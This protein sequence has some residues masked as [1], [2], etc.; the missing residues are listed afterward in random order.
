MVVADSRALQPSISAI[1][2]T[3]TPATL[4]HHRS[5]YAADAGIHGEG[6]GGIDSEDG[7]VLVWHTS[8][9]QGLVLRSSAGEGL[10]AERTQGE[11]VMAVAMDGGEMVYLGPGDI[12]AGGDGRGLGQLV[13][14]K[15]EGGGL[16]LL[17]FIWR[18]GFKGLEQQDCGLWVG[19]MDSDEGSNSSC[20]T[21]V[22]AFAVGA[23]DKSPSFLMEA[24]RFACGYDDG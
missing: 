16:Q 10:L 15:Q 4:D 18:G 2:M 22:L 17:R 23:E 21:V 12:L 8:G 13:V 9:Q 5:N 1:M 3:K 11:G 20:C 24:A 14:R 6:V 19:N 7:A